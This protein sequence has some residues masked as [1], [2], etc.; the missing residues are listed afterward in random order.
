MLYCC[1]MSS[2]FIGNP[3]NFLSEEWVWQHDNHAE[4]IFSIPFFQQKLN[5]RHMNPVRAGSIIKAEDWNYRSAS[6][7]NGLK[8]EN[9]FPLHFIDEAG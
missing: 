4:E 3:G 7:L 9:F 8:A 1:S 2:F 6:F 5:Y